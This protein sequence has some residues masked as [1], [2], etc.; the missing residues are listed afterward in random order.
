MYYLLREY[1]D[2]IGHRALCV[3]LMDVQV[4]DDVA[5]GFPEAVLFS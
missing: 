5:D 3:T 2:T 4:R 1:N